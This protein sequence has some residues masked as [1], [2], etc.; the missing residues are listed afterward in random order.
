MDTLIV[1]AYILIVGSLGLYYLINLLKTTF[2]GE[3]M[4]YVYVLLIVL[5][6]NMLLFSASRFLFPLIGVTPTA[7]FSNW[8]SLFI[9]AQAVT[10]FTWLAWYKKVWRKEK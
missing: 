10:V 6:I 9:R 8:W 3:F 7:F 1:H 5:L 2:K 4:V